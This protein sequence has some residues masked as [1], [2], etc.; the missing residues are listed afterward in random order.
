VTEGR[1]A[2]S[3]TFSAEATAINVAMPQ[4]MKMWE[5]MHNHNRETALEH[6][7]AA[8]ELLPNQ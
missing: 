4:L 1:S 6:A 3:E 2:E 8:L 5:A 7:K